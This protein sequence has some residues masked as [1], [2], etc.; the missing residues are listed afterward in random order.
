MG[1]NALWLIEIFLSWKRGNLEQGRDYSQS[2]KALKGSPKHS[3]FYK[4][5]NQRIIQNFNGVC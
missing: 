5:T 2:F 1:R 3:L 4:V